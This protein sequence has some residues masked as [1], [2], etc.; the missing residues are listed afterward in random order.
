M[1]STRSSHFYTEKNTPK[2][3]RKSSLFFSKFAPSRSHS[4]LEQPGEFRMSKGN[5]FSDSN[6]NKEK[7]HEFWIR[8]PNSNF[9]QIPIHPKSKL[10]ILCVCFFGDWGGDYVFQGLEIDL[11]KGPNLRSLP[12][13]L[14][15]TMLVSVL[16]AGRGEVCFFDMQPKKR[17]QVMWFPF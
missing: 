9:I 15:R 1:N 4:W 3:S 6:F 12:K 8:F 17:F 14:A 10:D 11:P 16:F 5:W 7:I 13:T 2:S